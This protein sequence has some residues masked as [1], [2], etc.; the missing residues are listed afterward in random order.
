MQLKSPSF[1]K[2]CIK[3]IITQTKKFNKRERDV[4]SGAAA[5]RQEARERDVPSKAAFGKLGF[6][7]KIGTTAGQND[8]EC[9][10]VTFHPARLWI[11]RLMEKL[12]ITAQLKNAECVISVVQTACSVGYILCP[13]VFIIA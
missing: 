12:G 2:K 11:N 4:P 6:I 7:E 13:T 3:F 8:E 10:N 1:R 5:T 9:G